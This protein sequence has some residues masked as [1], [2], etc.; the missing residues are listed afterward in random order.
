MKDLKLFD[1]VYFEVVIFSIDKDTRLP[2]SEYFA[3]DNKEVQKDHWY[4][5]GTISEIKGDQI[6][7]FYPDLKT[8]KSTL[9]VVSKRFILDACPEGAKVIDWYKFKNTYNYHGKDNN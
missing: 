2:Q 5:C 9:K 4:I 3:G 7:V 1:K 6:T 8:G